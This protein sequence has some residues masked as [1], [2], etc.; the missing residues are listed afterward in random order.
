[1][2]RIYIAEDEPGLSRLLKT[3]LEQAG[4]EI[5]TFSRGRAVLRALV[6]NPPDVLITDADMARMSGRELCERIDQCLA[7]RNFPIFLL[8]GRN[9]REILDWSGAIPNLHFMRKPVVPASRDHHSVP[10]FVVSS[11]CQDKQ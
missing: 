5:R 8:I 1:M 2:S 7:E 4:H 3:M 11:S 6:E 10:G 9:E